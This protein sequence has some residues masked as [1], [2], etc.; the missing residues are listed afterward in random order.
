MAG[1]SAQPIGW[2]AIRYRAPSEL[3]LDEDVLRRLPD[4]L[5]LTLAHLTLGLSFDASDLFRK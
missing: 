4:E 1:L 5:R 3:P 2:P